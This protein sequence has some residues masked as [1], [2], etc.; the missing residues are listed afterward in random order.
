MANDKFPLIVD[1]ADLSGLA[2]SKVTQIQPDDKLSPDALPEMVGDSGAG[3][4]AGIVP[5]PAAG[6]A[7]DGRYLS[8]DGTWSVPAGGGG[9]GDVTGP[10][11]STNGNIPK[12]SG[13]G[14]DTLTDG[15]AAPTGAIVG[16]S[17]TQTLTN[18]TLAAPTIADFTGATHTH[19][20]AAGAGTLDAA[21]IGSGTIATDRLGSGTANS[22]TFLRGDQTYATPAG[23]GDVSGPGSSTAGNV[24][25]YADTSGTELDGGFPV[26]AA[27]K[28]VL[29]DASVGAM[30]DT[31]GGASATGTGGL[32][33]AASPTLTTPALGTPSALVL[34]NATG[35]PTAGLVD[36]AVTYAKIQDVSASDRLLGRV[37]ASAG[38][39]EEIV[40]TDLAQSLL[41]DTTQ[42]AMQT[43]LGVDPAGTDNSTP[44]TLSGSLDYLSL[45]GQA[46]TRG[47]IDLS[48][49]VTGVLPHGNLG[50]GGGGSSKF[51]RED[52]TYQEIPGGGDALTS[53]GLDQFAATTS[54]QLA[55]VLSDETG[56]GAAVFATSPT[57]VTP[58]LGVAAA[59]SLNKVAV[60]APATSA[61][62]TI[63]DGATLTA[64]ATATVSGTNTGD[65]ALAGTPDY[66]TISG[67][68][69]T[70]GQV[71]LGTDV[72]SALPIANGG[73]GQ[74]AQTA[75]FNA[76]APTTTKGDLIVDNG[77]DAVRLA[78]SVTD[79]HVLTV[80]AAEATGVKW[81]A[82][83]GGLTGPGLSVDDRIATW[84]GVG[85]DTLQDSGVVIA[86]LQAVSAKDA[87]SGY[88][89]LDALGQVPTAR[90]RPRGWDQLEYGWRK[91][92]SIASAELW[93]ATFPYMTDGELTSSAAT[94]GSWMLVD[95]G[96]QGHGGL[97]TAFNVIQTRWS[98][99]IHF[100]IKTGTSLAG[101]RFWIGISA[102]YIDD[103]APIEDGD[104]SI[105]NGTFS[106]AS[107]AFCYDATVHSG[108]AFWRAH[109]SAGGGTNDGTVTV[110]AQS[111][112]VDT[113]YNLRI[114]ANP[115]SNIEFYI[116]DTLVATHTTDLP[117]V[118][119]AYGIVM[120]VVGVDKTF[121]WKR[122]VV[123]HD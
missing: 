73:T 88:A 113:A 105:T 30:V 21:A 102:A 96:A 61:T 97:Q 47:P 49:D 56:S 40:C 101:T 34:T 32:V 15:V 16:T 112:A 77:T 19:Q 66:I 7:A 81:A 74:T 41:D 109:T 45:S 94:G 51:L 36:D 79:G 9:S 92:P 11:T 57:L 85:G 23:G 111:I 90:Q 91:V 27:A 60:T 22:N 72:T 95:G 1:T 14:G 2:L 116:N 80:D 115:G 10:A 54:A 78:V 4:T 5:A 71:D 106:I 83:A 6:D 18:K 12:W 26:S 50:T 119:T 58:V 63:A 108:S 117:S 123:I 48:T 31:L 82:P 24:P 53:D 28:T 3:G 86:D 29:D 98:P 25:T 46:I 55:G 70:R 65:V 103:T 121:L 84:D 39:V 93:G 110:T 114:I 43:T 52:S 87:A 100:A 120:R 8:A 107:A 76:L 89:G 37:S 69:I 62:L 59:T 38:I 20:N 67:Q 42:G 44:V 64:S 68:T 99:E 33:R 35:L 17:D 13:T 75:G 122:V 118:S 104:L